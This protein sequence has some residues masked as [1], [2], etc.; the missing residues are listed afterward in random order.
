M[1]CRSGRAVRS[2]TLELLRLRT[3]ILLGE[4]QEGSEERS[5][6]ATSSSGGYI[7]IG[8]M[9]TR[10]GTSDTRGHEGCSGQP[11]TSAGS[12]CVTTTYL[13][14]AMDLQ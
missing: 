13:S 2:I 8:S 6:K 4:G 5:K 7:Q 12:K 1:S 11:F 3:V 14:T 9:S 10:R